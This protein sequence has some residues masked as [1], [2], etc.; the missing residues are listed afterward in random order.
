MIFDIILTSKINF[1]Q[2]L[3]DNFQ[4]TIDQKNIHNAVNEIVIHTKVESPQNF[5][6]IKGIEG[7]IKLNHNISRNIIISGIYSFLFI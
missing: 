1:L 4:N 3:S 2:N 6:I 7:S 5:S